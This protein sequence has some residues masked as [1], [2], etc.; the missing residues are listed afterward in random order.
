LSVVRHIS[1][2][3]AVM[4]LGRI[5]ETGPAAAVYNHPAHPYTQALLSAAP[6]GDPARR[7]TRILLAGDV[8]SPADP[9]SGCRFRTR[10]PIAAGVCAEEPGPAL[11]ERGTGPG[12][13]AACHFAGTSIS[14]GQATA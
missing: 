11:T 8:P 4:Y 7:R 1:D 5:V 14:S 9:P 10:C 13:E 12:H 6:T 2:R 3:V